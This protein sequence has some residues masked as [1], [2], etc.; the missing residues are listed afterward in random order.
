MSDLLAT[1]AKTKDVAVSRRGL[2]TL[3][4]FRA[5]VS[6]TPWLIEDVP[7]YAEQAGAP[8]GQ[9]PKECLEWVAANFNKDGWE[10]LPLFG[11]TR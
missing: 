7:R 9:S 5:R 6:G 8:A 11:F 2:A 1:L 4:L 3:A 10:P